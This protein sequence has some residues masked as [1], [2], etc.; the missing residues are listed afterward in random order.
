MLIVPF[1][2]I[3]VN[4]NDIMKPLTSVL[5]WS[6]VAFCIGMI[7]FSL[8]NYLIADKMQRMDGLLK[9]N[10]QQQISLLETRMKRKIIGLRLMM[11]FFIVLVEVLP[12]FQHYRMLDKWHSLSPFVRF[13]AYAGLLLLQYFINPLVMNRKFGRHL[14]SL[15]QLVND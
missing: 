10:L 3:A 2:F 15:K 13:G 12:Y 4:A 11:L 8:S 1:L 6:Y 9:E 5:Y 7:V 14:D